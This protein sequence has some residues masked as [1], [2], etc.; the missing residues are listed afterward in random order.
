MASSTREPT[1]TPVR[2]VTKPL[3]ICLSSR[4][5]VALPDF[6]YE[7]S[8]SLPSVPFTP[9][10]WIVMASPTVTVLP[11][12][13]LSRRRV[14]LGTANGFGMFRE[15]LASG[16]P[17]T[18]I[19]VRSDVVFVDVVVSLLG[20]PAHPASTAT[21]TSTAPTRRRAKRGDTVGLRRGNRT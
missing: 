2:P 4:V 8:N 17:V 14:V 15:G 18:L 5:K 16:S 3:M 19:A 10:Y 11:E 9:T 20:E 12:P 13:V 7:V 1:A 21:A 6:P